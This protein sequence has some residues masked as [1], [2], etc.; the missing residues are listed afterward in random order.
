MS[1]Y[2]ACW[3]TCYVDA[4]GSGP[5]YPS[6][7][8][9][10]SGLELPILSQSITAMSNQVTAP[11]PGSRQSSAEGRLDSWKEIASYLRREV[12]TVQRWEKSANLPVHRLQIEKQS[13]VYAYKWE[14]D[15]WYTER[16]P[17]LESDPEH[18]EQEETP[19]L[20]ESLRKPW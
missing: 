11:P 20:F 10:P 3:P 14:L 2:F 19:T 15:A 7:R 16:R 13:A 9:R 17:H 6:R 5:S 1:L 12:R 4:L 8:I 18:S